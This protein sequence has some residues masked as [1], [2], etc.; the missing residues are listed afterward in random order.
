MAKGLEWSGCPEDEEGGERGGTT[1]Y[2]LS[3]FIVY[4]VHIYLFQ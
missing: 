1:F 4:P 2:R 3:K